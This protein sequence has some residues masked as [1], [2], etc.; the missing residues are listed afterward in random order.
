MAQLRA[1][2]PQVQQALDAGHTLRLIHKRL[3][4]VG[5]EISYKRLIV[6]RGRI[7]RRKKGPA[8][9]ASPNTL[10]PTRSPDKTAPA[11]DPWPISAL[12]NRNGCP[13]NIRQALPT[14]ASSF[15]NRRFKTAMSKSM[16]P[17]SL[18]D[19]PAQ[20]TRCVRTVHLSLQGKGGVGKSLIAS[21]IA[22]FYKTQGVRAICVDTDPVNQTF[23]QYAALGA[24]HLQLMDGNQIDR[25]RFDALVEGHSRQ[26]RIIYRR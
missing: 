23:S 8:A 13:G 18:M 24:R 7:E 21:F 20:S 16:T 1:V 10:L 3:N 2:W 5:I 14:K 9:P 19:D 26:R 4:M 11:F 15:E 17:N 12:R 25:R 6:Y 22:Q